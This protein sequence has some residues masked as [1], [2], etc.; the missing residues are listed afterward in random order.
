MPGQIKNVIIKGRLC[1]WI[2]FEHCV[3][4]IRYN[5][6][7]NFK[8]IF[9]PNYCE[10]IFIELL[11][12]IGKSVLYTLLKIKWIVNFSNIGSTVQPTLTGRKES[13]FQI[14]VIGVVYT[15]L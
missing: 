7:K 12:P 2:E 10:K 1:G 15:F 3:T 8:S 6:I 5:E 9:S 14:K 11:R 13:F 4:V